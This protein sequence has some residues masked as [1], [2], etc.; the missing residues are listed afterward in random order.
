[1]FEEIAGLPMHP[2][3]VH[4]AAVFVPLLALVAGAYVLVPKLRPRV[5]WVAAVLAVVAPVAAVVARFSGEAF[6]TRRGFLREGLIGDHA[7]YGDLTMLAA[8]VLGILTLALLTIGRPDRRVRIRRVLGALV[9]VAA[10][11]AV[12]F[13]VLAG[14]AG[15]RSVWEHQWQLSR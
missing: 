8:L 9:V 15:A 12:V 7:R 3:S 11:T 2:L 6:L 14:D 5:G 1:M 13:V 4:A 10:V